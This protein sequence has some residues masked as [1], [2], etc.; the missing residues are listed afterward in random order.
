MNQYFGGVFKDLSNNN[1]GLVAYDKLQERLISTGKL[2]TRGSV[3]MI[4]HMENIGEIEQTE[5]YHVYRRRET[6][7]SIQEH[8]DDSKGMKDQIDKN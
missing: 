1:S 8:R 4:E 7:S 2:D 5:Q 3:L 6:A